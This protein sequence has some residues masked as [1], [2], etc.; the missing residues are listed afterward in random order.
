MTNKDMNG[1]RKLNSGFALINW[2]DVT[3]AL[4]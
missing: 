2:R 4:Q 1:N 3:I